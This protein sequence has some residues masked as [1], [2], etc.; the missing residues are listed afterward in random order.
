MYPK[1]SILK[2]ASGDFMVW[3]GADAL[4]KLLLQEGIHEGSVIAASKYIASLI[5]GRPAHILDIGAN[6]GSYAIPLARD[7]GSNV[8]VSCFEIQKPVF[9]QLCGNIF[10]NSLSNVTAHNFAVGEKTGRISVP[11]VDYES[12]FNVGGY[13][14][15][16]TAQSVNRLDFPNSS[17]R[18]HQLIQMFALDDFHDLLPADLIKLDIECYELEAIMGMQKYLGQSGFPPLIIELFPTP[19]H[20]WFL[21]KKNRLLSHLK[22]IGYSEPVVDVGFNNFLF[23]HADSSHTRVFPS[24]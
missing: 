24:T 20:D 4:G 14:I 9:Y 17:L 7:L 23:Q 15:D 12:C 1:V 13:S 2:T 3:S 18:E 10:L 19:P 16:Q 11:T 5:K 21:P 8:N 6:I 22:S